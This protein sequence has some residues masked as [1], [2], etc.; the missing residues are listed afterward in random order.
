M[1]IKIIL[2]TGILFDRETKKVIAEA[3]NGSFCLLPRHIDFTAIIVPGILVFVDEND[4]E[5]FLAVDEGV[6]VKRA[7][8]VMVSTLN[9][10]HGRNLDEL[11]S[12]VQTKFLALD[13]RQRK[14]RSALANLEANLVR[15]FLELE[16]R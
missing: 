12:I 9:A 14:T 7:N 6:I 13:E 8:E 10:V 3:E 1:K 4:E 15:K 16:H 2:P 11:R 5:Q